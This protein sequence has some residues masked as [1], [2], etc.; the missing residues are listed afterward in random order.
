MSGGVTLVLPSLIP[1]SVEVTSVQN[2]E[3]AIK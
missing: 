3:T 2:L 1:A